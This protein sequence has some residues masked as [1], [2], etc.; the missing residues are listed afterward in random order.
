MVIKKTGLL[1]ISIIGDSFSSDMN[2][3]SWVSMLA[4]IHNV[5]NYSQR[6]I[7]EYRLY[8][9]ITKNIEE[10]AQADAI[11]IFHTN[12]DRIFV[13][14]RVTFH[15]R[16]LSTH[17]YCD[18]IAENALTDKHWKN[19]AKE[20]YTYFFDQTQ[21]NCFYQVLVEKINNLNFKKIIHCSGF[22]IGIQFDSLRIQSFND[23]MISNPGNINHLDLVGNQIVYNYVNS[24]LDIL[25]KEKIC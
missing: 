5:T 15:S 23:V 20:Y 24:Q 12:P 3:G 14:D 22:D 8:H 1:N 16:T 11:I 13:P 4:N 18:M 10:I 6:G 19:I 17:T 21:Q 9:N 2:A 7:S 25:N